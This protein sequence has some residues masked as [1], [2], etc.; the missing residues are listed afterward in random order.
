LLHTAHLWQRWSTL[1]ECV[2]AGT[3]I[4]RDESAGRGEDWTEAFIAAMHRNASERAPVVVR[5]VGAENVRR[6]LDVGGGSGAYS[7][8]FARANN[9][10]RADI[11]D[12][13]AVE[14]IARRH[15][16][17]A[18]VADRVEVR[19]GDLRSDR[20]GEGYDLV[21]VSAICHMLSPGE[22]LD[23]LRRCR[24]ALAP[25]GR[26][27]I[28]DF[29]LEADKTAPRFAALFALNMLVGT[30]GGSSYSEPEYA[31]WLGEAGFREVRHARLPGITG[32]MIGLR[33]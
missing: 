20:L 22:N 11:L 32:L 25:G 23:L 13:A 6:M 30:R 28:Q 26:V 29:I 27:V 18:G 31:G 17:A 7:I 10:L 24:E 14:P 5:A 1:T 8:A 15:I 2:R 19:A 12:L 9:G 3:A 21:F 16:E 33:E 4:A